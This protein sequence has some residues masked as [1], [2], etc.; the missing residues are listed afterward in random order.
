MCSNYNLRMS[1][2]S[3]AIELAGNKSYSKSQV[4]FSYAAISNICKL[5]VKVNHCVLIFYGNLPSTVPLRMLYH[6]L[7]IEEVIS[8]LQGS[9]I[10]LFGHW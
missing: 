6:V 3:H 4:D 7:E 2:Y 9:T 10:I 1:N 5:M 8:E